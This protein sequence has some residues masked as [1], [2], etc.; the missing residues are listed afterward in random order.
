M[1]VIKPALSVHHS[2]IRLVKTNVMI[3]VEIRSNVC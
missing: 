2:G 3:I 1:L